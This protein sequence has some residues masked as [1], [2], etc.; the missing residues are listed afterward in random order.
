MSRNPNGEAALNV[1]G[2]LPLSTIDWPDRLSAVVFCQGCAWNCPYCHNAA[3]RPFGPGDRTWDSVAQWLDTRRG[4]LE[5]VVFSGGEP[6]LQPGLA[7]AMAQVRDMG[8][9]VGLHTSGMA[10]Q[11]MARVLP[12]AH[13]VG[14]DIKAPARLYERV[15]GVAASADA[16][17]ASLALLRKSGVAFELRTTWHPQVLT[18]HDLLEL[19]GELRQGLANAAQEAE[20]VPWVIQ[21]FQPDGCEDAALAET[22]RGHV[23]RQLSEAL[24]TALGQHASLVVR[25]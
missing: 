17:W 3:L 21:A 2:L 6:L 5:A 18:E 4:L 12:L 16:A 24:Q 19:A 11:A 8:Y 7:D 14:M 9:A 23:P 20:N 25:Q 15:T 22:G 13:W 10:T 1:G